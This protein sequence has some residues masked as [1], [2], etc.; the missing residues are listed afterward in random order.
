[1]VHNILNR[2]S[3][4]TVFTSR[5]FIAKLSSKNPGG[6]KFKDDNYLETTLE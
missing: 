1:M 6:H 2:Q 5:E 4:I 3:T